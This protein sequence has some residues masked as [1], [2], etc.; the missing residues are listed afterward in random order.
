MVDPRD[1]VASVHGALARQ[2]AGWLLVFDNVLDW[3]SVERFVPPAGPGRVLITT[4]N[5]H[6]LPGQALQ[7]PPQ[8]LNPPKSAMT[9]MMRRRV[10]IDMVFP[11]RKVWKATLMLG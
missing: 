8:P 3:T 9:R 2:E 1:P 5:Q 6:W 10:P 11:S 4:Q 7:P